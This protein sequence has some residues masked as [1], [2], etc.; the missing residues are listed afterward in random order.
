M[1]AA[2]E[3]ARLAVEGRAHLLF[4]YDPSAEGEFGLR[5]SLEG[6]PGLEQDWGEANFAEWAAGE[7]RFAQHFEP[8]E[9]EG[10]PSLSDWLAL[11]ESDRRG[12]T[13]AIELG[14]QT[15]A[16]GD[17]V[18]RAAAERLAIWSSL[19]EL[20]GVVSPFTEQIRAALE[21]ELEV[22]RR[23][24]VEG[25]QAE[26]ETAIAGARSGADQEMLARL[27]DRLMAL[28]GL[29]SGSSQRRN[30]A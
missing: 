22:E 8:L 3:R 10:A 14:E 13:P 27:T 15:L 11:A 18:A 4:R 5:A 12:K 24:L 2:L 20:T 17:R 16:V 23:K 26:H 28:A 21:Q 6:N 29:P 1:D 9:Q 30:G 19:K 25:L 7:G